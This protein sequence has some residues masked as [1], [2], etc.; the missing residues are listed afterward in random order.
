[1]TRRTGISIAIAVLFALV[2]V[3]AAAHP[4]E[5]PAKAE[6]TP[7][8]RADLHAIAAKTWTFYSQVDIDPTTSLPRD[9]VSDVPGS[10]A[11]TYTSPTNIGM[12]L[13]SI[14]AARDLKLIDGREALERARDELVT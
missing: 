6:L 4:A 5:P 3:A 2:A 7:A 1:M 12:Y 11:G 14:V 13:W 8:Q 9:N 10:P